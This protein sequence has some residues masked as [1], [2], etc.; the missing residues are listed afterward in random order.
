[1]A[2]AVMIVQSGPAGPAVEDEYNDWYSSTHIPENIRVPGF[3]SARR[4]RL[5][6]RGTAAVHGPAAALARSY[7]AI[8]EVE[9][10]DITAPIAAIKALAAAG[11]TTR[12][13]ALSSDPPPVITIY[14][15]ID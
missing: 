5:H 14:E 9:A 6:A 7:L 1:M 12:S 10:E 11:G 8:Y 4:F 15:L 2:R 13:A 3:L